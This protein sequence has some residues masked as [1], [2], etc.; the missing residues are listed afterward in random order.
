MTKFS[1]FIRNATLEEKEKVFQ[2]VM[3]EAWQDQ[4]YIIRKA[5]EL[6]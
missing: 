2:E 5:N 6:E 1:D 3:K 4:E